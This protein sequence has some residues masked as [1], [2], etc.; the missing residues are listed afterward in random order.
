M[1]GRTCG[2]EA[3]VDIAHTQVQHFNGSIVGPDPFS[4]PITRYSAVSSTDPLLSA[5][6]FAST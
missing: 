2:P 6:N 5:R 4:L 3:L 1:W